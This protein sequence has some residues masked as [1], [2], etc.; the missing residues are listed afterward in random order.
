MKLTLSFITLLLAYTLTC[1][2]R[3]ITINF[4]VNELK[5]AVCKISQLISVDFIFGKEHLAQK[6]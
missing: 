5:G 6:R 4:L 2:K 1:V 3:N